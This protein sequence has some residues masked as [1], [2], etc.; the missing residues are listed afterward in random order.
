[1]THPDDLLVALE[2]GEIAPGDR[3]V[4]ERHLASCARCREELALARAARAALATVPEDE[5]PADVGAAAVSQAGAVR[6]GSPWYRWGAAA[7]GVAAA[8]L[9]AV[10]VLPDIG[11]GG[12]QPTSERAAGASV[13]ASPTV[14]RPASGIESQDTNYDATSIAGIADSYHG[15]AWRVAATEGAPVPAAPQTDAGLSFGS[16]VDTATGCLH[17]ASSGAG[18]QLVRLIRARYQGTPAYIGV[19]LMGPGADQAADSV[20]VLVVP[21]GSC[22]TILSS[23]AARL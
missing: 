9:L 18:G 13:A 3:A 1:M 21:V 15:Y 17:R 14:V 2:D 16:S 4:L 5:A 12:A 11:S 10:I 6:S 22:T 7:V 19:Y 20:R 8:I 23:A